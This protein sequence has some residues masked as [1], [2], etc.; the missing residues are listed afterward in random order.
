M[1]NAFLSVSDKTNLENLAAYLVNKKVK[2]YSTGGTKKYLEEKGFSVYPIQEI[3]GKPEAFNGRM[4]SISF[5]LASG[6]LYRRG[7]KADEKDREELKIPSIDVVVVN[8]YPFQEK[9]N[10]DL[11][12]KEMVDWID[13]G[14]PC[15]LRAAAKNYQDVVALSNPKQYKKFIEEENSLA[16]RKS[17]A[18]DAFELSYLYDEAIFSH[19]ESN[20][21]LRYG[22]NPHQSASIKLDKTKWKVVLEKKDLSYNNWLDIKETYTSLYG[23]QESFPEYKHVCVVKH[24][25]PC[26]LAANRNGRKALED[27]WAGDPVSAFGSIVGFSH[28]VS[29]EEVEFLKDKFI[30]VVMAPS[31]TKEALSLLET[32]KNIRFIQFSYH[33]MDKEEKKWSSLSLKQSSDLICSYE[34][35]WTTNRQEESK[36]HLAHYAFLAAKHLKSNAI[37]LCREVEEGFQM[38]GAGMGQPNRIDCLKR[39]AIPRMQDYFNDIEF[40]KLFLASD[41][42]FPFSDVVEICKEYGIEWIVQPGGSIR[43]DEVIAKANEYNMAMLYTNKRHFK[44]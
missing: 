6:I 24:N 22:E 4:K 42:F 35:Q 31:I 11:S 38:V 5:E 12:D 19:F 32:K 10:E 14:G 44:H 18:K 26:G 21:E 16:L 23:F 27:A 13:I 20:E 39:L 29:L 8:F 36:V 28:E 7:D 3:T 41:A 17:F 40:E 37:A 2:L 30:E 1:R 43:D 15:L 9:L 25:N 33:Q 34:W